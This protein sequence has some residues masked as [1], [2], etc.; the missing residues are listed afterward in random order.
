M[1]RSPLHDVHVELNARLVDFAGYEMPIQYRSGINEEHNAVRNSCGIFDVSHMGQIRVTGESAE[2]FLQYAALND[3][4]RLRIGRA[5]YSMLANDSGG[6]LDDIYVNRDGEQDFLLIPN[7]ANTGAV[8]AHLKQ[9]AVNY[10]GVDVTDETAQWAVMAVQGPAAISL[11][12]GLAGTDLSSVRKNASVQTTIGD[13]S[14]SLTRTGYTGEDGYEVYTSPADAEPVW[15]L[16]TAAGAVPCGL[17]ARDT[18]RLEAGFPLYGN[19]IDETT[20]PLCT[21]M[22]WLVKEKDFHGRE[23][24][25]GATCSRRL[26]GLELR[27]RGIPRHGYSIMAAGQTVGTITSGTISPYTRKAIALGW[28]DAEFTEAGTELAVEI[29]GQPVAAVITEPPFFSKQVD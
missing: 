11:L 29:R 7:A 18:L 21:S 22:A 15:R 25:W 3:A 13:Y 2:S 8:M 20:N 12:S 14:A 27:E 23:R 5:H 10:P 4:G 26:V 28:V 1:K 9:L 6:V 19:D 24:L 17:G 16:I